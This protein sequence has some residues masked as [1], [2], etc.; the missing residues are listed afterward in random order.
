MNLNNKVKVNLVVDVYYN[1]SVAAIVNLFVEVF[2]NEMYATLVGFVDYLSKT[3]IPIGAASTVIFLPN[4]MFVD[5]M[6]I[7]HYL[8]W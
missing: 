6:I 4:G 2:L 1:T 3:S 8:F 5:Q 7:P